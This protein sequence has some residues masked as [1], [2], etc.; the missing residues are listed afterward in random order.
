MGGS[1][2]W[3]TVITVYGRGIAN[4]LHIYL[5][6]LAAWLVV[7]EVGWLLGDLTLAK[8]ST[9]PASERR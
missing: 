3:N 5:P 6:I 2:Y 4:T 8:R 1:A 7:T 9:R